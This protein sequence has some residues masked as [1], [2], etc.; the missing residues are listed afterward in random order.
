[1]VGLLQTIGCKMLDIN[2][3]KGR[4]AAQQ[5]ADALAII[6]AHANVRFVTTVDNDAAVVDA[7]GLDK[8]NRVS[9]VIEVKSRDMDMQTLVNQFQNEWLVTFEKIQKG[10]EIAKMLCVP[11]VGVLYLTKDNLVLTNV[12]ADKDGNLAGPIR[13]A[14]SETQKTTNGGKIIRTNAYIHMGNAN[15]YRG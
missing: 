6:T 8:E 12:I 5:Q 2:T 1:M 3:P 7:F 11:F 14:R 13:I 4:I 10:A 9:A 15:V